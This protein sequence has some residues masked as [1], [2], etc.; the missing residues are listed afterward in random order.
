[1]SAGAPRWQEAMEVAAAAGAACPTPVVERPVAACAGEV[2]AAD[3]TAPRPMPHYASSAMDGFA[4]AGA[5]PWRLDP[6]VD[7]RVPATLAPGRARRVLT[8]SPVP[9]GA[10]GV[11]RSEYAD[12]DEVGLR[13]VA[14]APGTELAPGRHIRP[15]GEE[16]DAGEVLLRAG[17]VLGPVDLA[18][19]AVAGHDALPVRRRPRVALVRTGDEVDD[20]GLP[21]PGR[22]RDAFGPSLPTLIGLLGGRLVLA[23]HVPDDRGATRAALARAAAGERA[24][25]DSGPV[26]LV[27]TTGAT[28]RSAADH[29]RRVVEDSAA[30]VLLPELA[31]RPGHPT[32][33][34]RLIDAPATFHLGLP[35]NPLAAF[36]ALRLV[37]QPFLRGMLGLPAE[38]PA[39]VHLL[40]A[41]RPGRVDRLAPARRADV[42]PGGPAEPVD[43]PWRLCG[44]DGSG[45]LRGLAAAEGLVLLATDGPDPDGRVPL[46]PLALPGGRA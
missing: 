10:T 1:M 35:G 27:L 32:L 20:A 22:V 23:E 7:P 17:T 3:V 37:G 33:L 30:A 8:G 16:S 25:D 12:V 9:D 5:G 14:G 29:V 18:L 43:A 31:V 41:P 6:D 4:V 44:A 39:R 15:A 26:D 42:L 21:G 13:L 2:L 45:M 24:D 46:L 40:D 34:A 36:T 19:A 38:A 28:A 11:V